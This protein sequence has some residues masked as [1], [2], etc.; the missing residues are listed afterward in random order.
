MKQFSERV[1][2]LTQKIP[3]GKVTTYSEIARALGNPGASR[4]VGNALRRNA[5]PDRIPCYRVV[6][7]DGSPGGYS[8]VMDSLGKIRR[9]ERDGIGIKGKKVDLERHFHC[10][11]RKNKVRQ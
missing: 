2:Q 7:S 9:L 8:G 4:A 5:C 3:K 10:F 1:L 11:S 6:R